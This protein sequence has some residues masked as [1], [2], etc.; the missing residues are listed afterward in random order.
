MT[1]GGVFTVLKAVE[2]CDRYR[3]TNFLPGEL[4][5]Q[6]HQNIHSIG[7]GTVCSSQKSVVWCGVCVDITGGLWRDSRTFR[8]L[9]A[10][11]RRRISAAV[12]WCWSAEAKGRADAVETDAAQQRSRRTA[13]QRYELIW[14]LQQRL[15]AVS[16]PHWR[17]RCM[18][19]LLGHGM[20]VVRP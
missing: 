12:G 6:V 15:R 9:N 17:L 4:G 2:M 14:L 7:T 13:R 8:G 20:G 10:L 16:W 11:Y 19:Q 5:V 18:Q 1:S 3:V